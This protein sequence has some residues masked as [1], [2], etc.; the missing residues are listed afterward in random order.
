MIFTIPY[1]AMQAIGS[2]Y[3]FETLSQGALSYE[4]GAIAFLVIMILIVFI[5]GMKGVA[6]TDAAQGVFMWI[7]LV[8]GSYIVIKRNFPSVADAYTQAASVV[9]DLFTMPG[10]NGL[11]TMQDW[12]SRWSVITIGMMM[13]PHITLRFFSSR[14]LEVLK[15]SSVFSS[16]YLTTIYVFIPAVGIAGNLLMPNIGAADTIFPE[17]LLRYTNVVF[18]SL[19]ISGALAASMST[20]DSQLH[21]V[22]SMITTDI[23]KP[24]INKGASDEKQYN[25]AKLWV[26]IVGILSIVF[27]LMRPGM[28]G[29]ILALA[30]GGVVVLSPAVLG[31]L[32]WKKSNKTAA[33]ASIIIGE[34]VLVIFSFFVTPPFGFMAAFWALMV[35]LVI[36]VVMSLVQGTNYAIVGD[37]EEMKDYFA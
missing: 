29:D 31:G 8:I 15:W 24:Y 4:V 21:A 14:N 6:F 10:P 33:F 1:V 19:V 22:G 27:A 18:A 36:F 16:I 17:L 3:I 26:L 35:A 37:L 7:G 20:G 34:I 11:V 28:L 5:G 30:N 9:P 13:F 32:F 23:Y 12:I 25:V 2:G